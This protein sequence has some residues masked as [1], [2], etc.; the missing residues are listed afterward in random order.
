MTALPRSWCDTRSQRAAA[1][2]ARRNR[3]IGRYGRTPILA[4]NCWTALRELRM[5]LALLRWSASSSWV[6]LARSSPCFAGPSSTH[7]L[8]SS[9]SD[10]GIVAGLPGAFLDRSPSSPSAA[11]PFCQGR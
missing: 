7:R 6:P 3:S 9:A 10:A 11:D 8:T 1:G 2:S 5:P 4:R